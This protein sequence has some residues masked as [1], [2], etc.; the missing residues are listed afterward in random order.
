ME[1]RLARSRLTS[2][3]AS[4][5]L[6]L[7]VRTKQCSLYQIRPAVVARIDRWLLL[8]LHSRSALSPYPHNSGRI[9]SLTT[10]EPMPGAVH[11]NERLLSGSR[12]DQREAASKCQ[13]LAAERKTRLLPGTSDGRTPR[14][15]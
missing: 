6:G 1:P 9:P 13:A 3:L 5:G 14:R 12:R 7:P 8:Q 15:G 10:H 2:A 11:L 4:S